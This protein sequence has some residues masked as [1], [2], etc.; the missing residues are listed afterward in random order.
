MTL[1]MKE[2]L[3][4]GRKIWLLIFLHVY[5]CVAQFFSVFLLWLTGKSL[6]RIK[7]EK[8]A[9]HGGELL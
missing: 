8:E 5:H 7:M 3:P 2:Y 4:Q 9:K 1:N 6:Y